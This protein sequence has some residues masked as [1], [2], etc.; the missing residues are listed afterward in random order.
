VAGDKNDAVPPA[1]APGVLKRPASEV[2]I[3]QAARAA[4]TSAI[5]QATTPGPAVVPFDA[6]HTKPGDI[7][8]VKIDS[9]HVAGMEQA[10]HGA[11][12]R[13]WIVIST[14]R[15]HKMPLNLVVAV[16]LT[17]KLH[18]LGA[19]REARFIVPAPDMTS[20]DPSWT[21]MESLALTEQVRAISI[22]RCICKIGEASSRTVS[23]LRAGVGYIIGL[24]G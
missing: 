22:E 19:F 4:Q 7:L 18:H 6:A 3:A 10:D 13:P 12:P 11:S 9:R 1:A 8:R 23:S 2:P 17:T 21:P 15:A 20:T 24:I 16:P 5:V 14:R